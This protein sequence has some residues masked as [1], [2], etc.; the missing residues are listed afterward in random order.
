MTFFKP[1]EPEIVSIDEK[2]LVGKNMVMSFSADTTTE[3]WRSFMPRR[4]EIPNRIS[5]DLYSVQVYPE[6]FFDRFDHSTLFEKWALA[7]VPDFGKV[8]P[9]M[10]RFIMPAGRYAVFKYK[11]LPADFAGTS[12]YILGTW[13]PVSGFSLDNRPHFEVLGK[14]YKNNDPESE[15]EVWIPIR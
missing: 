13:L 6:G 14:K 1:N 8:P 12:R 4:Y 9:G 3:L 5:E 11:G 7:E 10:Q 2:K 15:E